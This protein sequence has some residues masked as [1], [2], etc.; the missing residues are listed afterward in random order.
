MAL[1]KKREREDSEEEGEDED[2][3]LKR[4]WDET[5]ILKMYM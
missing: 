5:P 3:S 4:T 2:A 1:D